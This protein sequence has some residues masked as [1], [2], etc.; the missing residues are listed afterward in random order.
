[1]CVAACSLKDRRVLQVI[2][3]KALLVMADHQDPLVHLARQ[4]RMESPVNLDELDLA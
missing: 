3:S 4:A 2:P 1:M